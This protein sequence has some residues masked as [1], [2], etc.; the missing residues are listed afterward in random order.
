LWSIDWPGRVVSKVSLVKRFLDLLLI[1]FF[2]WLIVPLVLLGVLLVLAFDGKPVFFIQHR[3]GLGGKSFKL[4]KFRTMSAELESAHG[5]F[6]AGSTVRVTRIGALL[7][8]TKLDE[9]PQLWN[10]LCGD[11]SLV[12]PRPEVRKWVDAYPE[13]WARVHLVRPGITDP[14]SIVYRNEEQ[15]LAQSSDPEKTYRE[16]VLPHKLSLYEKYVKEQSLLGDI[17]ILFQTIVALI[18]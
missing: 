11:M 10:V 13:R 15:L 18:R 1:F 16:E 4:F 9:L 7:R 8:R 17:H 3:I 6:D 5:G 12:G 2:I 14:A